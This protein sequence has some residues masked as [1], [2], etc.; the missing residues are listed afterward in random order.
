MIYSDILRDYSERVCY[1]RY[2]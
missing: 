1:G 2:L